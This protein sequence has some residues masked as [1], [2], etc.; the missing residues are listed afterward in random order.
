MNAIQT[1]TNNTTPA[2]TINCTP[3]TSCT[4]IVVANAPTDGYFSGV[5]NKTDFLKRTIELGDAQTK[6]CL[7]MSGDVKTVMA[8]PPSHWAQA[9]TPV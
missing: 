3:A 4:G 6:D 7:P 1:V 9:S 8:T 2:T 5:L